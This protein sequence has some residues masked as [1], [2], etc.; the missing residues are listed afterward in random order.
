MEKEIN[1][2]DWQAGLISDNIK[3]TSK[4]DQLKGL[5]KSDFDNLWASAIE[6]NLVYLLLL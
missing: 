6:I 1:L 3:D 2:E 4:I 5:K